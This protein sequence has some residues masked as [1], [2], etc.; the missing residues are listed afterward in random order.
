MVH[1]AIVECVSIVVGSIAANMP[2]HRVVNSPKVKLCRRQ[3]ESH[4][5]YCQIVDN[6]L[7]A[8]RQWHLLMRIKWK[9]TKVHIYRLS[10]SCLVG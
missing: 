7:Q 8:L 9:P 2:T 4:S 3:V 6:C 5:C 10:V 1:V